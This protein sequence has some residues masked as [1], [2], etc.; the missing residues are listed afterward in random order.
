MKKGLVFIAAIFLVTGSSFA[1]ESTGAPQTPAATNPAMKLADAT[2]V[3]LR[4]KE[5]LSSGTAKVG[6]RVP[7]RVTEDVKAGNLIIIQRW[8]EAWGVVSAVQ[9]KK[10][11]GQPGSVDVAIQSVQLL[12]GERALLRAEKHLK[13]K[14]KTGQIVN[15]IDQVESEMGQGSTGP[16]FQVL[17]LPILPLFLLEKGKDALLPA[18]TRV[19]AYLNGD[20]PLE[21]AAYERMQ[22]AVVRRA[23]PATVTIFR[24]NA[25]VHY[26]SANKP[27]VYCG[28]IALARLPSGGYVKIQLPPGKYSLRSNDEQAIELQLEEGQEVYLGMQMVTHGLSMKGHLSQ[29]SNSEGEDEIAGLHELSG[30]DVA[31]ISGAQLADLQAMPEKK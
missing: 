22:P 25:N 26:G 10:R 19:T 15:D 8:A 27:S 7:F 13:G 31:T 3:L 4:M 23:G 16:V 30:K 11:K 20:V 5:A 6:D 1:Q 9:K 17:A 14:D 24:E 28:K 2:P 21:R 12:S 29:V 18:G